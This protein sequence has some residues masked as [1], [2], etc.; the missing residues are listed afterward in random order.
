[1]R[2]E[3]RAR[4]LAVVTSGSYRKMER[5]AI[6]IGLF[7]PTMHL[8]ARA[9]RPDLRELLSGSLDI[10]YGDRDYLHLSAA[11]IGSVMMPWMVFYQR[12]AIADKKL[13]PENR[14][15]MQDLWLP[16]SGTAKLTIER[17]NPG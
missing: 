10:A 5:A 16:C 17:V 2:H 6:V 15:S 3:A 8:V 9:V 11:N 13:G 14:C 7:E 4:F 1:M 12:L